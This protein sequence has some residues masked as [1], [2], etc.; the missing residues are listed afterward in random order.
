MN[1][2]Q[3]N[4]LLK[5]HAIGDSLLLPYEFLR[6]DLAIKRFEKIGIKQSLFFN[7]GLTSDDYDHLLLTDIALKSSVDVEHFKRVLARNLKFW[8]LCLPIGIG[9]T[10][11]KSI[12]KLMLGFSVNNSGVNSSGNGP[13]MRVPIIA[14]NFAHDEV[15]RNLYIKASTCIT[16]NSE[17]A[18]ACSIGMGNFVAYLAKNGSLPD[19]NILIQILKVGKN[20][21][22]N[23]YIENLITGL[24]LNLEE[25]LKLI[26]CSK[27]VSGYIMHTA[28][29]SVYVLYS[30]KNIFEQIAKAGGDTDS[31]G[32]LT[33]SC[34]SLIDTSQIITENNSKM[35]PRNFHSSEHFWFKL[36]LKNLCLIPIVISH[37]LIRFFFAIR[38]CFS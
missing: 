34:Q 32:A 6:K 2:E 33:A 7:Y 37:G 13:L 35:F 21:Q 3:Y 12:V 26:N 22:W 18:I 23:K 1:T 38:Y 28:I 17:Q 29:F 24:E 16:H 20:E 19:K 30:N 9:M 36:I 11:L 27:G 14:L 31:V 25:F 8:L 5:S 10:T 15:N 4:N